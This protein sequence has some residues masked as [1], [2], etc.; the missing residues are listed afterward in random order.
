MILDYDGTLAPI[1]EQLAPM[2]K[3]TELAIK[4][5]AANEKVFMC[6]MSGRNL[7]DI[8]KHMKLET[9][10]YA[11]NHGLEVEYP[12]KSKFSIEMPQALLDK[13]GK[14]LEELK[15]K[16]MWPLRNVSWTS[17]NLDFFFFWKQVVCSGAW[18]ED[19]KIALTYHYKGVND[20]LRAKLIE[21]AKKIIK[22]HGFQIIDAHYAIE[23]KPPVNWDKGKIVKNIPPPVPLSQKTWKYA[24]I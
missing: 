8:K 24:E 16:V 17:I 10:T 14:L 21:D 6:I 12:D 2:P 3:D 22:S 4:K 5:L 7:D 11:A 23:G 13:Y 18:V 15:E 1:A 19:K 9:V 20:K